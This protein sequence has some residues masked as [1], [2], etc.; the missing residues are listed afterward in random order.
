MKKAAVKLVNGRRGD[1][2]QHNRSRGV[3]PQCGRVF[4]WYWFPFVEQKVDIKILE[5]TANLDK[6]S[7]F[8]R[9]GKLSWQFDLTLA[10]FVHSFF[11]PVL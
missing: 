3:I 7:E 11:L 8:E 6:I 10:T 5:G 9:H 2:V 1:G 4:L